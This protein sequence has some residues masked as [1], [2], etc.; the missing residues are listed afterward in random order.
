MGNQRVVLIRNVVKKEHKPVTFA[1]RLDKAEEAKIALARVLQAQSRIGF[2]FLTAAAIQRLYSTLEL[3]IEAHKSI[4]ENQKDTVT[5][6]DVNVHNRGARAFLARWL[7]RFAH[8]V[9]HPH[10]TIF[11]T[12]TKETKYQ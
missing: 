11:K 1:L 10:D 5:M 4:P 3:H 7:R 9:E 8:A 12:H 2:N 6:K